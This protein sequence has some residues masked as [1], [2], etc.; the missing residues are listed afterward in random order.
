MRRVVEL[1][2][3]RGLA[4]LSIVVY[5]LWFPTCFFGWTR[6][7]LFFVLSGFLVTSVILK[8]SGA[9]GFLAAFFVRRCLRIWPLYYLGL[10]ALVAINPLLSRPAPMDGVWQYLT[11]TQNLERLWGSDRTPFSDAY[12]HTWSLALEFRFYLFWPAVVMVAGRRRLIPVALAMGLGSVLARMCGASPFVLPG[13]C[14]GFAA[15]AI[16][17]VLL[18]DPAFVGRHAGR[19]KAGFAAAAGVG[20]AVVL[21]GIWVYRDAIREHPHPWPGLTVL[22][23][24]LLYGGGIGLIALHGGHRLLAP[25]RDPR[26]L[27]LGT[28]SYAL[29]LL[30]PLT[31][32]AVDLVVRRLGLPTAP[33]LA[34][35][36]FKLAASVAVAWLAWRCVE[37]PL[38]EYRSQVGYGP[39]P[40]DRGRVDTGADPVAP[41]P[42]RGWRL[43]RVP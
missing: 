27:R 24:N 34:L 15:G 3:L 31:F 18:G 39:R 29:Y 14:D 19:L 25:L 2:S 23:L 30:H 11:L 37:R 28:W 20:L 6:V 21:A 10:L 17:A 36:L 5:H 35:D 13:R 9:G 1:D 40:A 16:L 33:T 4:A 42:R 41:A 12:F 26:L 32:R 7:D 8:K 22:A 38:A 43:G